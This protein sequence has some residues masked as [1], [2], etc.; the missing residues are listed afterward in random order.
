MQNKPHGENLFGQVRKTAPWP[1]GNGAFTDVYKG[2]WKPPKT[3]SAVPVA[4]KIF[5]GVHTDEAK[6]KDITR[7]VTRE[8]RV[9]VKLDHSNI[10][11]YFG[12]CECPDIGPSIALVSPFCGQGTLLEYLY[13]NPNAD[14]FIFI[15]DIADGLK[16]LHDNNVVHGDLHGNNVLVDDSGRARLSDFGRAKVIGY[17]GYSTLLVAGCAE[18]MAPELLLDDE[19]EGE[20]ENEGATNGPPFSKMSDVYAFSM[21]MFQIFTGRTPLQR[22][23]RPPRLQAK[24]V[25]RICA[26]DRPN[27]AHDYGGRISDTNWRLMEECWVEDPTRR[28]TTAAVVLR[29]R[30]NH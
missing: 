26:G 20:D 15:L 9:W 21:L 30:T 7:R 5:R 10:Q 19:D 14:K 23:S 27:R 3:S 25:T 4:I 8:S 18:Y 11:P 1:I 28:P 24:V 13:K 29:L 12:F 6:R 16:Y 2:E 17:E 22:G